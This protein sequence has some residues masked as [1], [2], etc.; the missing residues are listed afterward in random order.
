MLLRLPSTLPSVTLPLTRGSSVSLQRLS[1]QVRYNSSEAAPQPSQTQPDA[2]KKR[3]IPLADALGDIS[4]S[5]RNQGQRRN[6]NFNNRQQGGKR[7]RPTNFTNDGERRVRL[8]HN[9][10]KFNN[11]RNRQRNDWGDGQRRLPTE[12]GQ[13][14]LS[15]AQPTQT[16]GRGQTVPYQQQRKSSS[17]PRRRRDED[18]EPIVMPAPGRI[19]L[20]NLDDLFGPPTATI[21]TTQAAATAKLLS[22]SEH[23]I[24]LFF[25]RSAGD[26]SRYVANPSPTTDVTKLSPLELSEFVLSKRKDVGLKSRHNA[27]TIVEKF[28]GGRK[29]AEASAPSS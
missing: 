25:E 8:E 14:V 15:E 10:H 6:G 21:T 12:H 26:Y 13:E 24:Q 4:I 17:G 29:A 1:S 9:Q 19:E 3:G 22:P 2:P 5:P 20:G 27:L 11:G 28:V 18:D 23:R 7:D 16:E